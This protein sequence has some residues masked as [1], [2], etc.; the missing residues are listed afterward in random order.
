MKI[1]SV[2]VSPIF[3][4]IQAIFFSIIKFHK[5]DKLKNTQT[6]IIR[7]SYT[8]LNK[9]SFDKFNKLNSNANLIKF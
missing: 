9:F 8:S 4:M 3:K 6:A 5:I 2:F 1:N 7:S